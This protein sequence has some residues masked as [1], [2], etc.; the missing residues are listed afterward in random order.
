MKRVTRTEVDF[1]EI[2]NYAE[3]KFK[4]SWNRANDMF[5]GH[6]LDYKSFN[7][8]T[9]GDVLSYIFADENDTKPYEELNEDDKGYFIINQFMIDND[10][11]EMFV[12]NR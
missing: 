9:Q 7:E 11:D 12:N 5:F 10:I 4:V 8:F 3:K 1:S 6:S 2:F